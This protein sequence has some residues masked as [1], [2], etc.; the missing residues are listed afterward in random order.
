M[1]RQEDEEFKVSQSK[2]NETLSQKQNT[3]KSPGCMA[4]VGENTCLPC[5]TPWTQSLVLKKVITRTSR[6]MLFLFQSRRNRIGMEE[7]YFKKEEYSGQVVRPKLWQN[8]K[9]NH[10]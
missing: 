4:Q 3:N 5:M 1:W 8:K 6:R 2:V 7:E 9:L 10:V